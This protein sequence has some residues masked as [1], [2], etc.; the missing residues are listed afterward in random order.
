MVG[1]VREALGLSKMTDNMEI[2]LSR[3][4]AFHEQDGPRIRIS[5][6]TNSTFK[7]DISVPIHE[8]F[9]SPTRQ[10]SYSGD[11]L[12]AWPEWKRHHSQVR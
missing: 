8:G 6:N 5:P 11:S 12:L 2:V 9:S 3:S 4:A 1:G 7:K 10:G